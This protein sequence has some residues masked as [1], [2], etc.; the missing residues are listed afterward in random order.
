M[1]A[2]KNVLILSAFL[3]MVLSGC[4]SSE[5]T[6]TTS[7]VSPT[8]IT[9]GVYEL[10]GTTYIDQNKDIQ[11]IV[12]LSCESWSRTA[13]ADTIDSSGSH[14]HYNAASTKSY[15][16]TDFL[17]TEYGPE[18]SQA[19]IDT[20]CNIGSGGVSKSVNSTDY[21]SDTGTTYLRIK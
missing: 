8:C 21:L 11:H 15:D 10:V 20:T 9:I 18:H 19:A 3:I 17:W 12:D 1:I 7:C 4:D 6:T 13:L 14:L 2:M 16:G 5:D